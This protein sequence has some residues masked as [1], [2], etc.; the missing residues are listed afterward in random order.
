MFP[1]CSF[2]SFVVEPFQSKIRNQKSEM[3]LFS[4]VFLR[5]LCGGAFRIK[6]QKSEIRNQKWFCFPLCPFVSFVVR[7]I[8]NRPS[9]ID[10][11]LC[12]ASAPTAST[13]AKS[14]PTA[15]PSSTAV[16]SPTPTPASLS[17]RASPSSTAPANSPSRLPAAIP[18]KNQ[19]SKTKNSRLSSRIARRFSLRP[20]AATA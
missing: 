20:S 18:I 16:P 3:V 6:N 14:A 12:S 4:P 7:A 9:S 15:A 5:V 2:V 10:N 11:V 8:D 13:C 17:T 19:K 1:S